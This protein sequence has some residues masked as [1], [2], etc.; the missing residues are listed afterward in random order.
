MGV[1]VADRSVDEYRVKYVLQGID[2]DSMK[3]VNSIEC[4]RVASIPE[5]GD[6]RLGKEICDIG[7]RIDD[8]S[9]DDTNCIRNVGTSN[10]RL[11][12]RSVNLSGNENISRFGVERANPVLGRSEEK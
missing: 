1:V 4:T 9:S 2:I 7:V 12:E 11:E 8:W 10:I 5:V 3:V 6:I